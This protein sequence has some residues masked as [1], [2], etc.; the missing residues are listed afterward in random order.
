MAGV[1]LTPGETS[2]LTAFVVNSA[3]GG[4]F[5]IATA[6]AGK[7]VRVYRVLLVGAANAAYA[8]KDNQT[9][10]SGVM[11]PA[12]GTVFLLAYDGEPW[13]VSSAGN[14]I[15]LN[16]TANQTSGVVWFTQQPLN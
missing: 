12:T 2:R 7:I 1:H 4:D 16:L 5:P 11:T 13:F 14:T 3:A 6:V 8:F 9:A 10:L 15:N